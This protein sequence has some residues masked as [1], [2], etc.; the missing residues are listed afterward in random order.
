MTS[1]DSV[2][3]RILFFFCVGCA[4]LT[5]GNSEWRLDFLFVNKNSHFLGVM[6]AGDRMS[7]V[8][9]TTRREISVVPCGLLFRFSFKIPLYEIVFASV[10]LW[11]MAQCVAQ[12][13]LQG[14]EMSRRQMNFKIK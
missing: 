4:P 8:F 7:E 14:S 13:D 5:A 6:R 3:V 11:G 2:S 10:S 9:S 12:I 1:W